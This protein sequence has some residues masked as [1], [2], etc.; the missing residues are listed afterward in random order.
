MPDLGRD[1]GVRVDGCERCAHTQLTDHVWDLR[2]DGPLA[3]LEGTH[4][5]PWH[6]FAGCLVDPDGGLH[7][8]VDA[9]LRLWNQL[10]DVHAAQGLEHVRGSSDTRDACQFFL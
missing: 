8:L 3:R 9:V 4:D 1:H 2:I 6:V 5:G 7:R 10:A